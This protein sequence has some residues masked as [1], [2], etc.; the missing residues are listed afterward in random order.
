MS[1]SSCPHQLPYCK[2]GNGCYLDVTNKVTLGYMVELLHFRITKLPIDATRTEG[3]L[4]LRLLHRRPP[5]LLLHCRSRLPQVS[6]LLLLDWLGLLHRHSSSTVLLHR[7]P[8]RSIDAPHPPLLLILH[9]RAFRASVSS[10]EASPP[11][12]ALG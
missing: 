2:H 3:P 9:R 6:P 11:L 4:M 1:N 8:R 5:L 10:S 7:W 12:Y